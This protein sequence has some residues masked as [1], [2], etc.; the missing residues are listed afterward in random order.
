ML[1]Y[2]IVFNQWIMLVGFGEGITEIKIG[3]TPQPDLFIRCREFPNIGKVDG[4]DT[5]IIN[6]IILD[7]NRSCFCQMPSAYLSAKCP[8]HMDHIAAS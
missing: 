6:G 7:M 2:I 8:Y 5:G 1:R 4:I 3:N